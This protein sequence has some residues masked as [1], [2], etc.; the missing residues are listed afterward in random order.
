MTQQNGNEN[1]STTPKARPAWEVFF[2]GDDGKVVERAWEDKEKGTKGTAWNKRG[3]LW[4]DT[5]KDGSPVLRGTITLLDG[6]EL[7][8]RLVAPRVKKEKV[9]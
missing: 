3:A 8:L 1:P 7:R 2:V 9:A 4:A 5:A 6:T